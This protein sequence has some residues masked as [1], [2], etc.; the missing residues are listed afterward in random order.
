[1]LQF[2][3]G[4]RRQNKRFS[5]QRLRHLHRLLHQTESPPV[6]CHDMQLRS[7]RTCF[8][9]VTRNRPFSTLE[10]KQNAVQQITIFVLRLRKR[11]VAQ[12]TAQLLLFHNK[13]FRLFE[14]RQ[15]R[16][17]GIVHAHDAKLGATATQFRLIV[18]TFQF[19]RTFRERLRNR[20]QPTCRQR[21]RANLFYVCRHGATDTHIQVGGNQL[22]RTFLG[23][24]TYIA[25]HRQRRPHSD[26]VQNLT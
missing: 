13:R 4:F 5:A 12:P 14:H 24:Q 25:Q 20:R 2:A 26:D 23:T 1:M 11:H 6:R 9:S 22:Q 16:E 17:L 3:D 21:N 19:N 8:C 7:R 10:C 15:R 18:R